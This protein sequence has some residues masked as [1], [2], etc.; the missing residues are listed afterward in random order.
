[1]INTLSLE[2]PAL[3]GAFIH[4]RASE[5]AQE[6]KRVQKKKMKS[7]GEKRTTEK[8]KQL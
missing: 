6:Q 3:V 4:L 7:C 1:M 2:A 5:A 8:E